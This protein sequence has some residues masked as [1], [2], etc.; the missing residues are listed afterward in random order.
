MKRATASAVMPQSRGRRVMRGFIVAIG[1]SVALVGVRATA[2]T[3]P[4]FSGSWIRVEQTSVPAC[5]GSL[6][7]TQDGATMRV[8][9]TAQS[10]GQEIYH[11]DGTETRQTFDGTPAVP[12][13][14]GSW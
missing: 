2:Q 8:A 6:T 10:A 7:I 5:N 3:R 9:V 14:T 13:Q 11:F 4:D 12:P 1:L